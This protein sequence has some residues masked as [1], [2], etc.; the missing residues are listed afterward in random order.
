MAHPGIRAL[1]LIAKSAAVAS[2]AGT[3]TLGAALYGKSALIFT[4]RSE[5]YF[6]PN[7]QI[8]RSFHGVSGQVREA[9]A[10]KEA[11]QINLF[12]HGAARLRKAIESISIDAEPFYTNGSM[13]I[14]A[15]NVGRA[16]DLLIDL[17]NLYQSEARK[18]NILLES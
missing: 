10:P 9:V 13:E 14:S 4:E 11:K 16:A 5:F 3:V 2:L 17:L 7:V 1:D 18:G 12:K 8:V 15:D 6:L